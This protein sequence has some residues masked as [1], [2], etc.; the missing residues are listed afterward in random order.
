MRKLI[1]EMDKMLKSGKNYDIFIALRRS[2]LQKMEV[3]DV[4]F[5]KSINLATRENNEQQTASG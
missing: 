3:F 4:K 5:H 2:K 1:V